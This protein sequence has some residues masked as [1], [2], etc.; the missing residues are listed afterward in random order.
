M[1]GTAGS[2]GERS[3]DRDKPARLLA[4]RLEAFSGDLTERDR[5]L[6]EIVLLSAMDPLD[7]LRWRDASRLLNAREVELL[8]RLVER[9]L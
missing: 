7:R 4:E 9:D 8:D 6:L 1:S 2:A 3:D 5:V